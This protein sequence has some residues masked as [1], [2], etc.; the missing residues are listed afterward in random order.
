[1]ALL[2]KGN[3]TAAN[4]LFDKINPADFYFLRKK[5][6]NILYLLLNEKLKRQHV[7]HSQQLAVLL[8]ETGY[9]RLQ[10]ILS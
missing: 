1:M 5:F 10:A 6:T 2:K 4:E 9:Y 3:H 8:Q 7:K